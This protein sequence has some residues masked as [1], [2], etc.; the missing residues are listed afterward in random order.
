MQNVENRLESIKNYL[1][2]VG[3]VESVRK[4]KVDDSELLLVA[5]VLAPTYQSYIRCAVVLPSPDFCLCESTPR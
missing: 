4:V 1:N 2:S 5:Y 3:K